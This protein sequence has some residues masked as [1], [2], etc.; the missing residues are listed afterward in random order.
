[1]DHVAIMRK[2]WGLTGKIL[3]NEKTIESRWYKNQYPPW[4]RIQKGESVYFKNSGEPVSI[5]A[6]VQKV[7]QFSGL[8]PQRVRNILSKY[9]KGDGIPDQ[10]IPKFYE[11]FKDKNYCILVFLSNSRKIRPFNINK[12]G[13]G[14]MSAWICVDNIN[15]IK[16]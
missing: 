2:S 11:L 5:V 3:T 7:F 14:V 12:T 15:Q 6:E 1:M 9:A 8:D 16:K 10:D 13:F 4:D